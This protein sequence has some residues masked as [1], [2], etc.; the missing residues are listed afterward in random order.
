MAAIL[1]AVLAGCAS[2]K[3]PP[4]A[5]ISWLA[6]R[7]RAAKPA[8]CAMPMLTAMP[9]V[10]YQQ[11]AIVEISADYDEDDQVMSQLARREACQTGADALVVTA[12]QRQKLGGVDH[13]DTPPPV[14]TTAGEDQHTPEIGEA[15]HKGRFLNAVA[16]IYTAPKTIH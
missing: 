7:T 3:D 12:D 10:D 13:A 5:T 8:D 11:V 4:E 9:N 2:Q 6:P 1:M 16:I 15:G 14:K